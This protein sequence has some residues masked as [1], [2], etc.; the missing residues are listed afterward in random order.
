MI[1]FTWC[2]GSKEFYDMNTDM[3]QMNN[4]LLPNAK[5]TGRQYYGRSQSDIVSR[6]DALLM[7]TKGC[8][9]ASCRDPWSSLFPGGQVS[10]IQQAMDVKYDSFFNA[11]PKVSFSSCHDGNV[12]C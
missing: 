5:G 2:D 11:Q 7:V 10:T 6:L 4:L 8:K 9:E 12:L 1:F 3:A